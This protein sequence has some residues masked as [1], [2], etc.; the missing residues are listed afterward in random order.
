M[1]GL[2]LRLEKAGGRALRLGLTWEVAAWEIAHMKSCHLV[3][4]TLKVAPWE[5][6]KSLVKV[7]NIVS[8]D[9]AFINYV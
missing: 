4:N 3:K 7:P 2:A 5:N 9:P 1:G 8:S 6:T